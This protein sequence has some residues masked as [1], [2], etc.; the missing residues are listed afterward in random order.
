MLRERPT[1][2]CSSLRPFVEKYIPKYQAA[3]SQLIINFRNRVIKWILHN[4]E[5]AIPSANEALLLGCSLNASEEISRGDNAF[6]SHNL[7]TLL[8]KVMQED[9]SYWNAKRFLEELHTVGRTL[10]GTET[11]SSLTP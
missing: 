11:S 8:R 4:P 2:S 3:S 1:L 10:F 7:T 5:D 9:G 6:F